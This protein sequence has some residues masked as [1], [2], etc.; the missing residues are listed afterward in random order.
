MVSRLEES[1]LKSPSRCDRI[2]VVGASRRPAILR[3]LDAGPW[4]GESLER[5]KKMKDAQAASL[6]LSAALVISCYIGPTTRSVEAAIVDTIG[7]ILIVD[8]PPN[9]VLTTFEDD[10][11]V[12]LFREQTGLVLPSVIHVDITAAGM[13]AAAADLT[14]GEVAANTLVDSYLLH[15]DPL[16][17]GIPIRLYEGSVTFDRPILGAMMTYKSLTDTDALLGSAT[18]NY[19]PPEYYRGFE[20]PGFPVESPEVGDSL[21][22]SADF[23]TLSFIFRTESRMDQIRIVTVANPEPSSA[24]LAAIGTVFAACRRRW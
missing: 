10:K 19:I 12:R 7:D 5:W 15:A 13:V 2:Q 21:E 9:V 3:R 17:R 18:T 1:R 16:N 6:A 22:I 4:G 11:F 20:G 23:H 24:I 14:P 8:P